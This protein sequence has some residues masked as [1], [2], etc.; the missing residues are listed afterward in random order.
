MTIRSLLE[1]LDEI[2]GLPA[3]MSDPTERGPG[4]HGSASNK[5]Q[6]S[7]TDYEEIEGPNPGGFSAANWISGATHGYAE[8]FSAG[9]AQA[10]KESEEDRQAV[11]GTIK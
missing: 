2:A 4:V 10:W 9:Y 3:N 8:G 1:S 5:K 11:S 6:Y 7:I